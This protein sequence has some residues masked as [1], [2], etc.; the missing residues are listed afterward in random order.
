[1]PPQTKQ[2]AHQGRLFAT[3]SEQNPLRR[4]PRKLPRSSTNVRVQANAVAM[5]TKLYDGPYEGT[6]TI[7]PK[8]MNVPSIPSL[9]EKINDK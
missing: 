4:P 6:E 9:V 8:R 5:S 7:H 3:H 1:M 2:C